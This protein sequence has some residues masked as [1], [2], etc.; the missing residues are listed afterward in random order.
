MNVARWRPAAAA[1]GACLGLALVM[2]SAAT[3]APTPISRYVQTNLVSD[4]AGVAEIMDP[5]LVNPWGASYLGNSPLWVSD[6]GTGVTTL[7][8]GGVHGSPQTIVPLV[9]S[10][11]GGLPT[12]Q[13]SNS[14]PDF[15]VKAPDGTS[16]PA[17]FIFV[18]LTGHI[19]GWNPAVGTNGGTPP[20]T[21]AQNVKVSKG[22]AYTGVAM[23]QVGA[24]PRLYA[25]NF[26][27]GEVE[28]YG[29]KW[30]RIKIPGAFTDSQ[31]P[32]DFAPFNVMVAGEA[33]YVAYAERNDEGDEVHGPGLGRVDRYTLDGTL[34]QRMQHTE[35]LNA[36]WGMTIAPAGFGDLTGD[37]LV[38]NFGD[39]RIHAFDPTTFARRGVLL[40]THG[41]PVVIDGLWAILPGNGTEGGTDEIIFTAGPDDE[42]HGLLGTLSLA[43]D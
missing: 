40:D 18:G 8:S 33:V 12:G 10:I 32:A 41:N 11:P 38:G 1:A 29:P 16:G 34:V 30:G 9:V 13:V 15:V 36:P 20:S 24:R 42:T 27:T 5:N 31:L 17:F 39:G 19:T 14:T 43:A 2:P 35:R 21:H 25:A 22:S 37:L 4:Q 28:M 7:Y 3:A 26:A 23:G 6:N